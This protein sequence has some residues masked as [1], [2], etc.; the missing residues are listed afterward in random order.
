M[1]EPFEEYTTFTAYDNNN[2]KKFQ[3]FLSIFY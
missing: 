2:K 1:Q 3:V